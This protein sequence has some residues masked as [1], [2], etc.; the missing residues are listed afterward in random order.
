M[1]RVGLIALSAVVAGAAYGLESGAQEGA[2]K[3]VIAINTLGHEFRSG[4]PVPILVALG[5]P[6]SAPPV[7]VFL[8]YVIRVR[9]ARGE[10]LPVATPDYPPIASPEYYMLRGGES[11]PVRPVRGLKGGGIAEVA[12][13]ALKGYDDLAPGTYTLTALVNL[14][15][16]APESIFTRQ[17]FPGKLFA[18]S[19]SAIGH[20][21]LNSNPVTV[22]IR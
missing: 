3:F 21:L 5:S 17:E 15:T 6:E 22:E 4:A 14:T 7:H 1:K 13:N 11:V 10:E 20:Y 9:N 19:A 12:P 16:Y 18:P 8:S 2:P